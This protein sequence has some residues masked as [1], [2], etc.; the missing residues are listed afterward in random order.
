MLI[1][2]LFY[3]VGSGILIVVLVNARTKARRM[4]SWSKYPDPGIKYFVPVRGYKA[5]LGLRK[6]GLI[7]EVPWY[8]GYSGIIPFNR[9]KQI[10]FRIGD[11][12]FI[13]PKMSVKFIGENG[14]THSI[15]YL[16]VTPYFASENDHRQIFLILCET[17]LV[18]WRQTK[19]NIAS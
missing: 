1:K 10:N 16:A 18:Y 5:F 4:T 3:L 7:S 6:D 9:I 15:K 17:A 14:S 8:R 11:D 19:N 12:Y 13:A 2:L